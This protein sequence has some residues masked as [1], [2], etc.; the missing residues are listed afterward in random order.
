MILDQNE[1]KAQIAVLRS[2]LPEIDDDEQ[3][4][5]D[6]LEGQTSFDEV[7]KTLLDYRRAGARMIPGINLERANLAIRKGRIEGRIEKIDRLL[8]ELLQTAGLRKLVTDLIT[9]SVTR[10]QDRVEIT[11]I[12]ALPQGY[13]ETIKQADKRAIM[14]SFKAGEAIPGAEIIQG[15]DSLRFQNK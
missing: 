11:D 4:L 13:V 14:V 15:N 8:M 7:I 1:L 12:E 6:T 2:N 10:G 5:L 9:I 3:L